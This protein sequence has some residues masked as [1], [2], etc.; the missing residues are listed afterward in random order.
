MRLG[1][2]YA[3]TDRGLDLQLVLVVLVD[4]D[5]ESRGTRPACDRR[6]GCSRTMRPRGRCWVGRWKLWRLTPPVKERFADRQA[7]S[8]DWQDGGIADPLCKLSAAQMGAGPHCQNRPG[9][10]AGWSAPLGAGQYVLVT[11]K[12]F[13]DQMVANHL[14]GLR[15]RQ[16]SRTPPEKL[17]GWCHCRYPVDPDQKFA[18]GPRHFLNGGIIATLLDCHCL[19]TAL[20]KCIPAGWPRHRY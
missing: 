6:Q 5:K 8:D 15:S 2:A 7:V 17:L 14:L 13:Q 18:A 11:S 3:R 9:V 19:C 4:I 20:C 1:C 12:V 16:S 10:A